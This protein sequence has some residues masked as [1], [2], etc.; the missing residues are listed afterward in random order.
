MAAMSRCRQ[1]GPR[2]TGRGLRPLTVPREH[3]GAS[4][5]ALESVIILV[6]RLESA[7][8][9]RQKKTSLTENYRT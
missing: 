6:S 3:G 9:L 8:S 1:D 7:M 4:P 5:S 2:G